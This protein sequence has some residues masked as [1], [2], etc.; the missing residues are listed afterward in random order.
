MTVM[1]AYEDLFDYF[2]RM[3]ELTQ[4]KC[5]M[6]L[7]LKPLLDAF[8]IA[9]RHKLRSAASVKHLTHFMLKLQKELIA[10][11]PNTAL[12]KLT[13]FDLRALVDDWTQQGRSGGWIRVGVKYTR[14]FFKWCREEGLLQQ[15]PGARLF[16][17]PTDPYK[18]FDRVPREDISK[19]LRAMS[20]AAFLDTQARSLTL[21]M[22]DT[23]LR[24]DEVCLLHI[25]DLN[26]EAGRVLVRKR[27]RSHDPQPKGF[28]AA[29]RQTVATYLKARQ[30][31]PQIDSEY[32]FVNSDGHRLRPRNLAQRLEHYSNLAQIK[33]VTPH[34]LR[35]TS[36]IE[37]YKIDHDVFKVQQLLGHKYLDMTLYYVS[38]AA[39]EE[40]AERCASASVSDQPWLPIKALT[41]ERDGGTADNTYSTA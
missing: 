10:L 20:G 1:L 26:L 23:A 35:V 28:G 24:L 33:R 30:C 29:T 36:A 37:A 40:N 3:D 15:N 38:V 39:A 4:D 11:Y 6:A 32:L 25:D 31:L 41:N 13:V 9:K 16:Y 5:T 34:R 18:K 22:L 8:F 2:I 27:K 19:L 17:N 12:D 14:H 21:L 7:S